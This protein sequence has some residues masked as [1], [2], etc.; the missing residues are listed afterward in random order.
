MTDSFLTATSLLSLLERRELSS[1]ELLEHYLDR[2]DRLAPAINPFVT[3]A[4][5]RGLE[6]ARRA[7]RGR[8][9]GSA[10]GRLHGLPMTVKDCFETAGMRTTCGFEGLADYVPQQDAE[11]VARLRSAGAIIFGKTNL[12][13]FAADGQSF[14]PVAGTTNNPWDLARSPSGSSGGAAAALAMDFTPLELGSD[15]SGS[16]RLPA[17]TCGVFGLKP[18]YGLVP[19]RGHI[20][21]PPGSATVANMNVAG[22]LAR[23]ADDLELGFDVVAGPDGAM[24]KAW[25]LELPDPRRA[26]LPEYR[27]R[28]WLD[29]EACRVDREVLDVLSA[30]V[31]Q[32]AGAGATLE[33]G[34]GPVPLADSIRVHR[35]LL[36]GV[37]CSG[38]SDDEFA[39]MLGAVQAGAAAGED[40]GSRHLRW[41]TQCKRDWNA[42]NEER[43]QMTRR[44]AEFFDGYDALLCPVGPVA[45]IPHDHTPGLERRSVTING[46]ARPY[47]DQVCW[48][49]MA[50]A[51]YL[52][53]VSVPVGLTASGLPVGLQVIAPYL[54]D[55][56]ALDLARRIAEVTGGFVPP[57]EPEPA[58]VPVAQA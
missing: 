12:P 24:S 17:S 9:D 51:C 39:S 16:I 29:D 19:L 1:V 23:D 20:P 6:E 7:D 56:T 48:I 58:E 33:E 25:R 41:M 27:L 43:S 15:I 4:P 54:E 46:E 18:S 14:N 49:S 52:P 2:I 32:L 31:A 45:A 22:P 28:V 21:G 42:V 57:P 13:T 37:S 50:G 47:W 30:A 3:L 10:L 35:A 5:E 38:P 44:W 40:D 8:L 53:A 36:M 11:V 55:R 34:P 26:A